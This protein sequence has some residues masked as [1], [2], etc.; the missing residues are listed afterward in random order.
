M[1]SYRITSTVIGLFIAIAI[2]FL[3]RKDYI[4]VRHTI[5]WLGLAVCSVL[6][7]FF[8]ETVDVVARWFGVNYPP[9]FFFSL[10]FA[11]MLIKILRMDIEFSRQEREIKRLTQRLAIL[12]KRDREQED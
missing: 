7:G 4:H 5:W 3:V 11:A 2:I 9:T 12:E 1:I 6:V 10:G 8:P